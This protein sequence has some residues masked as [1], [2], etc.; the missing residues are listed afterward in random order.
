MSATKKPRGR[1]PKGSDRAATGSREFARRAQLTQRRTARRR[2]VR[3]R[4]AARRQRTRPL[5]ELVRRMLSRIPVAARVCAVLAFVNAACWSLITPPFQVPDEPDHFAYVQQLAEAG[6]LPSSGS[7]E[8]SIEEI[9]ALQ[10]LHYPSVRF[11]PEGH[12]IV[13]LAAQRKLE[14]DLALPLPRRGSGGAGVA[15]SQ[16]PLY[17]ALETIPYGLASQG[18]ILERLELMR[19]LSALMA[20]LTALFSFLFL[21]EALPG[22]P[23]AWTVGGLGVAAAPL[24]GFVSGGVNPDAMLFGVSAALFYCLARAFRRGLNRRAALAIGVVIAIGL[25]SKL[26]FIGLV[27]GAVLGLVLLA[28][29]EARLAGGRAVYLGSLAPALLIAASPVIL[30]ALVNAASGHPT[31]GIVSG[32]IKALT[33]GQASISHELSYI[34]QLYLPRLP[35]MHSYFGEILTTRQIWFR[36]LVGL[37]GWS[38]TVFPGWVYNL[39][40]IPAAAIAALCLRELAMRRTALQRRAGELATYAVIGTGVL[41]LVGAAGYRAVPGSPAEYGEPRYLLPMLALW[42]AVLALAARGAGRRWGPVVGALLV[43]LILAQDIF[44]QLQVIARYYG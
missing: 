6:R 16:P 13:S 29:R 33:S 8:Y 32:G 14:R 17:Y 42:G 18:T 9:F 19:L 15:A 28:R 20:G 34:W 30:Y 24:L 36:D 35:W 43:A 31:L 21:R 22:V 27:P 11:R 4:M 44:S 3:R 38:D 12:P 5:R 7:D 37:Y 1:Q 2:A 25:L 41:L 10:D 39:A 26:N 40:L 23:W